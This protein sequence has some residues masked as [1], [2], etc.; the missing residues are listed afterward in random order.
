LLALAISASTAAN[1]DAAITYLREAVSRLDATAEMHFLLGSEYAQIKLYSDAIAQMEAAIAIDPSQAL[2]RFQLG[3]LWL[4]SGN[5][6]QAEQVLLPLEALGNNSPFSYFGCGLCHLMRD[7]F[8]DAKVCLYQGIALNTQNLPLNADMRRIIT[9][10]DAL[11]SAS[12]VDAQNIPGVEV[13][14]GNQHLQHVLLSAYQG[15]QRH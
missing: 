14:E 2:V 1:S 10:I 7:Q 12:G 4:T 8:E 3:L 9:A 6:V 15:S 11:S 5:A 13:S